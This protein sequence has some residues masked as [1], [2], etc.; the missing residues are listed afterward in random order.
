M[1]PLGAVVAAPIVLYRTLVSPL[2]PARCR[3]YPSCSQYALEAVTKHG[4]GRG[5]ALAARRFL[6]CHPWNPGGVDLV[7]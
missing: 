3:F 5:L 6:R 1:S 7:P 4:A 2:L